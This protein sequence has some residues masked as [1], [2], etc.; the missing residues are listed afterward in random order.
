MTVPGTLVYSDTSQSAMGVRP[1]AGPT[2]LSGVQLVTPALMAA[3][4]YQGGL[5]DYFVLDGDPGFTPAPVGFSTEVR[6]LVSGVVEMGEGISPSL[7]VVTDDSLAVVS[8]AGEIT[9]AWPLL[10]EVALVPVVGDV[11]DDDRSEIVLGDTLGHVAVYNGDGSLAVGW[12]RSVSGPPRDLKLV[13]LDGDGGL[14]VLVLDAEGRFHGWDGRGRGLDTYPRPLGPFDVIAS[15]IS[16]LDGDGRLTWTATTGQ[17]ALHAM[18]FPGAAIMNGDWRS[19]G[20]W[21]EGGNNQPHPATRSP[22]RD[23]PK[24]DGKPL[25]VY[26]NPARNGVEIRFVLAEDETVDLSLLDLAGRRLT[27]ARL[28]TRGGFKV[29]ENAIRWDLGNVPPGLYFCRLARAGPSGSTVDMAKIV[30]VR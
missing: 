13:D 27:E 21:A 3:V 24:L 15:W 1:V 5:V 14:D 25:L 4:G 17:G 23:R 16:D 30:V 12:P 6:H 2:L 9:A 29:G 11:D 10:T 19:P 28:D 20:R 26:P 7:V 18:R 22:A 8:A